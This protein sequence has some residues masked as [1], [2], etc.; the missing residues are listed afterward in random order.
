MTFDELKEL[1]QSLLEAIPPGR[2]ELHEAEDLAPKCQRIRAEIAEVQLKLELTKNKFDAVARTQY[3]SAMFTATGKNAT[4][5]EAAA[6]AD[7]D[8]LNTVEQADNLYS[9][10]M[11][12][13]TMSDI[14]HNYHVYYRQIAKGE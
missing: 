10:I 4:E 12:C 11:Y 7:P 3:K 9:R 1:I 5:K 8:Y 14:F 13:R 2:V 6:K